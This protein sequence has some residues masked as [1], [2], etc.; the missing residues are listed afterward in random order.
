MA[1]RW[2]T[3]MVLGLSGCAVGQ[4][5][6]PACE[7]LCRVDGACHARRDCECSG[8]KDCTFDGETISWQ[9]CCVPLSDLD[10][11]STDICTW[12]SREN[13]CVQT[14][15]DDFGRMFAYCGACP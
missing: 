12:P 3:V 13:C 11:F 15:L 5:V 4:P 8:P 2:W 10:C 7:E 1:T 14:M 6:E 9:R